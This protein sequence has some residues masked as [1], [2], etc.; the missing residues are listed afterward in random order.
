MRANRRHHLVV[1]AASVVLLGSAALA[2]GAGAEPDEGD[3]P[4]GSVTLQ[5]TPG[6]VPEG[7]GEIELLAIVRDLRGRPL[8]NVKVNFLARIGTLASGGRLVTTGADG[9]AADRLTV[10]AAELTAV[11]NNSFQL[12]AAVGSG[13]T[14]PRTANLSVGI[15]RAPVASFHYSAGGLL[16]AFVDGSAGRVTS[17]RWD[18]GDGA[19]STRQSPA[20]VFAEPGFYAVTLR[21]EN[22]VG[23]DEVTKLVRVGRE[24]DEVE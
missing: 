22:A 10:T 21:A 11:G 18:F 23:E 15:Q 9:S 4:A 12:A 16:V 20:H 8:P 1:A 14:E 13:S 17:R 6:S 5:A 7:G 2:W 19:V 3:P 24:P